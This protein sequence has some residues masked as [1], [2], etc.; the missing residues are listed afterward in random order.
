MKPAPRSAIAPPLR[1]SSSRPGS[2]LRRNGPASDTMDCSATGSGR[3]IQGQMTEAMDA[4]FGRLLVETGLARRAD[5]GR[6]LYDPKASNTV[7]VIVG[8][9]GSLGSAVKLPF[10]L[11]RAKGTAPADRGVGSPDH[12]R[13]AGGAAGP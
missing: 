8:D 9:N 11:D 7:I 13:A 4:E 10:Q 1:L 6:L 12:C 5:D 2:L 3:L